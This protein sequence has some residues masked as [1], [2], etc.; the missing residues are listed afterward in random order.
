MSDTLSQKDF[1][2]FMMCMTFQLMHHHSL[3]L[4][5][6]NTALEAFGFIVRVFKLHGMEGLCCDTTLHGDGVV[7]V[8]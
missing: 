7:D 5:F 3:S 1:M 6:I 2:T 4:A 8:R